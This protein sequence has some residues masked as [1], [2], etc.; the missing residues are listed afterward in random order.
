M[1]GLTAQHWYAL[2]FYVGLTVL[3]FLAA[4]CAVA[5]MLPPRRRRSW[6]RW[7]HRIR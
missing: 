2:G 5:P 1:I 3:I 7:R 4:Y 6:F